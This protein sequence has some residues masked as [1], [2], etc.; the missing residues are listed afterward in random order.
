MRKKIL[1]ILPMLGLAV[2]ATSHAKS[3][4]IN[5]QAGVV[6]SNMTS[7]TAEID[8][9]ARLGYQ[10]GGQVRL[11]GRGYVAPGV[12]WQHS[13]LEATEVDDATLESVTDDLE[14]DALVVPVHFGYH[15][16]SMDRGATDAGRV[17][18]SR[19][20]VPTISVGPPSRYIHS[21]NSIISRKDYNACLK[22]IT[23]V[24]KRLDQKT[25]EGFTGMRSGA[26]A[27]NRAG[28]RR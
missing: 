20:G 19:Y 9:E 7:D 27:A 6:G 23:A 22:L 16:S 1:W 28:R 3:V 11:G 12:F 17:H 21:H 4:V 15:L 25:V 18:M 14:V 26:K 13:S 2:A 8:D 24:L 5:P 10:V